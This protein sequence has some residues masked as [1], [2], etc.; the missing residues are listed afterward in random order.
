[1]LMRTP[2]GPSTCAKAGWV[3]TERSNFARPGSRK[4]VAKHFVGKGRGGKIAG[5]EVLMITGPQAGNRRTILSYNVGTG[6]IVFTVVFGSSVGVASTYQILPKNAKQI[7]TLWNN[8]QITLLSTRAEIV[9]LATNK[10][11]IASLTTGNAASVEVSGGLGN[12]ILLFSTAIIDGV[13]GYRYYTGLAQLAQWTI[14]GKESDPENFKGIRAAGVQIEIL[15]PVRF[16]VRV[17][18]DITTSEGITLPLITNDVK[19]AVSAYI[20]SL[21]VG[22]DV[23]VSSLIFAVRGVSGVSDVTMATPVLNIAIADS[24]LARINDEDIIVG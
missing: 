10:V 13:D 2:T 1:M 11:Q 17:E 16:P 23:V 21:P 20:N 14:D 19:S 7:A 22:G 12:T 15:E 24:E 6:I 3:R 5:M 9:S 18:M 4:R 8:K